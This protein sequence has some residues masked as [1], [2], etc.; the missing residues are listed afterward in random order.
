MSACRLFG[1]VLVRERVRK[2][3]VNHEPIT[4]VR[5]VNTDNYYCN[6]CQWVIESSG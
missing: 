4:V 6:G 1:E 2:Q 3:S 5:G